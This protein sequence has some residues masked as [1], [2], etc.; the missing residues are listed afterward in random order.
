MVMCTTAPL[1]ILAL[2]C[3]GQRLLG[4]L[5][6]LG[7]LLTF[8]CY[9]DLRSTWLVHDVIEVAMCRWLCWRQGGEAA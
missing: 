8:E 6:M 3:F 1:I 7:V 5:G 4:L 9:N 2:E